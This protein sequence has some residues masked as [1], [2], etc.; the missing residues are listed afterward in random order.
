MNTVSTPTA[1]GDRILCCRNF[2]YIMFG[3]PS[4]MA[5]SSI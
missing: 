5:L 4:M 2:K 3:I 1:M